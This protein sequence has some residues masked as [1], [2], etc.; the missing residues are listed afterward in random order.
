MKAAV[1]ILLLLLLSELAVGQD[2]VREYYS[3]YDIEVPAEESY[4]YKV[5]KKIVSRDSE[6]AHKRLDTIF[7]DSVKAYYTKSN[8]LRSKLYYID[9]FPEG[10][11]INYYENGR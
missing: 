9:G 4:Y 1:T 6:N 10:E 3:K 7:V 8:M 11:Y 2:V 5:G